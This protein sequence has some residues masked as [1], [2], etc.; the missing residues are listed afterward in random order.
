MR[1]TEGRMR[2]GHYRGGGDRA[3]E[4]GIR[5]RHYGEL[6]LRRGGGDAG[7]GDGLPAAFD[8]AVGN[9]GQALF[10]NQAELAPASI[11][12]RGHEMHAVGMQREVI[13]FFE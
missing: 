13:T 8:D 2:C 11:I 6:P 10:Q 12:G 5:C 3:T 7:G 4:G 1:A 9:F